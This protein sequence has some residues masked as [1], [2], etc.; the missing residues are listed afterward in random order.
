MP[1]KALTRSRLV[2]PAIASGSGGISTPA[3]GMKSAAPKHAADDVDTAANRIGL[4]QRPVVGEEPGAREVTGA[5]RAQHH[6]LERRPR[7]GHAV[8]R[9]RALVDERDRGQQ[10]IFEA[11]ALRVDVVEQLDVGR[12]QIRGQRQR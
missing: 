8:E 3:G 4:A 11:Q 9:R 12:A 5:I 10:Q 7:R 6:L 2:C 1:V